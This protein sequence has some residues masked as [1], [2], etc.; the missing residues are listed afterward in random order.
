M[1]TAE[2][3]ES[4][5]VI[6]QYLKTKS[7]LST[8]IYIVT[9]GFIAYFMAYCIRSPLFVNEFANETVFGGLDLKIAYVMAQNI[10][11]ALGK[12]PSVL[13]AANL[14]QRRLFLA[15]NCLCFMAMLFI[16]FPAFIHSNVFRCFCVM[17]SSFCLSPIYAM[18]VRYMEGRLMSDAIISFFSL[19]WI[20][21]SS[22]VKTVGQMLLNAGMKPY[23]M[24][25]L[26]AVIG[27]VLFA[28]FTYLLHHSPPPSVADKRAKGLRRSTKGDDKWAFMRKYSP[29]LT[30]IVAAYMVLTAIRQ[31]RDYFAPE[32][33]SD[34][35]DETNVD[36]AIYTTTEL[37]VGVVA[38]LCMAT[39]YFLKDNF[40]AFRGML[41]VMILGSLVVFLISFGYL[42]KIYADGV[43]YMAVLG[44]GV[45]LAYI[46]PGSMLFDRLMSVSGD[47]MTSTFIIYIMDGS[48]YI[49]TLS[50]LMYKNFGADE[51]MSYSTFL[52]WMGTIGGLMVVVLISMAI[53]Y[54]TLKLRNAH[55][56]TNAGLLNG[57]TIVAGDEQADYQPPDTGYSE[58]STTGP[59]LAYTDAA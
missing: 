46:P 32:I 33:Y 30:C 57:N 2:R 55:D 12:I 45:F 23:E 38:M 19:S 41:M 39:F 7:E 47:N 43:L 26:L 54:F 35:L 8:A 59:L 17:A 50:M 37:P 56:Q 1:D 4:K 52:L 3:W 14:P 40:K 6:T 53:T 20:L 58:D 34:L 9:T 27:Y 24:T 51:D 10:G 5:H 49:C 22:V 29:G 11:Y 21:P 18:M 15:L 28:I 16:C 25:V 44:S 48:A 36:P 42:S 13:Y 31:F